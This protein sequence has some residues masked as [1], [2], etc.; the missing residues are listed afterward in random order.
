MSDCPNA[1]IRDQLPDLLHGHLDAASR[2]RVESHVRECAECRRE[3][4]LL[5]ELRASAP[6]IAVDVARIV[7]ALPT[8][9]A[10]RP[11]LWTARVWQLAAA[12]VFLA[13]GGSAVAKYVN[14]L[15]AHDSTRTTVVASHDDSAV[16]TN[17][18]SDIELSVGYG[19]SDLTDAQLQALLKDVEQMTAVPMAEPDVSIPNVTVNNGG[20]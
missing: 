17:G 4:E 6:E 16:G 1:E 8:A 15:G 20:V 2:A 13:V 3:L 5:R 7:S 19:Y 12:V 10:R 14:H 9:A 11:R 18:A